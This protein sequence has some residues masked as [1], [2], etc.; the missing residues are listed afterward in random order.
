MLT[1]PVEFVDNNK[2][3]I[4]PNPATNFINI[5][6]N[7]T[8]YSISISDIKGSLIFSKSYEQNNTLINVS[9]FDK[10]IYF[11]EIETNDGVI[12]K[13]LILQ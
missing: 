8:I 13:K 1:S 11:L 2:L 12:N 4:Y 9:N 6:N 5:S 3:I 7:E 10:G